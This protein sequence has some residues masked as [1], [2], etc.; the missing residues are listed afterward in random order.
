MRDGIATRSLD[1]PRNGERHNAEEVKM[2]EFHDRFV[3]CRRRLQ[4]FVL[5]GVLLLLQPEG[6]HAQASIRDLDNPGRQSFQVEL[7]QLNLP[8]SGESES[9]QVAEVPPGTR[10]VIEHVSFKVRSLEA[11]A[12]G[13]P[14]QSAGSLGARSQARAC[15]GS[16]GDPAELDQ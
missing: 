15:L 13:I 9:F 12:P 10:L 4:P 8:A 11:R 7:R 6:S 14:P 3:I 16:P 1:V 2:R 5:V